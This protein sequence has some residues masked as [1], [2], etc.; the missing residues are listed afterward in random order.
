M[1][2]FF[3]AL[4]V[5]CLMGAAFM[6]GT[7]IYYLSPMP[8]EPRYERELPRV[9]GIPGRLVDFELLSAEGLH[10][11][12]WVQMPG[13][14]YTPESLS[15][16][17]PNADDAKAFELKLPDFVRAHPPSE[18]LAG[19]KIWGFRR[20]CTRN[21]NDL[22]NDLLQHSFRQYFGVEHD[23]KRFLRVVAVSRSMFEPVDGL[24]DYLDTEFL[25]AFDSGPGTFEALFD[26]EKG[27]IVHVY[28]D[29]F[30]DGPC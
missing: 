4:L 21:E 11:F 9:N 6:V 5:L 14:E 12:A 23:G 10:Q 28:Y 7:A 8:Y 22:L 18:A 16:W 2:K 30:Y 29:G 1:K 27:L 13:G 26:M 3:L 20:P 15:F 25:M 24:P 17:K 19:D